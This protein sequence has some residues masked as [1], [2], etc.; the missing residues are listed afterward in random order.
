MKYSIITF[1]K[2]KIEGKDRGMREFV[3]DRQRG[4][5]GRGERRKKQRDQKRI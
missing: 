4:E 2:T 3:L 5:R 1:K